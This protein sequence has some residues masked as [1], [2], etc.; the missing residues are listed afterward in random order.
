[1][2]QLSFGGTTALQEEDQIST[3]GR[4]TGHEYPES[5]TE[6][7]TINDQTFTLEIWDKWLPNEEEN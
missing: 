2:Q 4:S 3:Q 5:G 7:A 6:E 1:M